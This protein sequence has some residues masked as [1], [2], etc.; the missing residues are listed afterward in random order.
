MKTNIQ[1]MR[2]ELLMAIPTTLTDLEQ[3]R[4]NS[5]SYSQMIMKEAKKQLEKQ[6]KANAP[7][8]KK[9]QRHLA[10]QKA[11]GRA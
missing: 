5:I 10:Q 7:L 8:L 9:M 1:K 4:R 11:N 6:R 2:E 3:Q